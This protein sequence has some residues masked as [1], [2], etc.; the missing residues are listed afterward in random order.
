MLSKDI[1]EKIDSGEISSRRQVYSVVGRT[2]ALRQWMDSEGILLPKRWTEETVIS[3]MRDLKEQLGRLPRAADDWALAGR[4]QDKFGSWNEAMF[5]AFGEY[6]QRRYS[7]YSDE[8]LLNVIRDYVVKF[9]QLPLREEFDGRNYPYFE[10]YTSRF[11]VSTWPDVI[12][13]VDLSSVTYYPR[14]H[15]FGQVYVEDGI[16]YLSRQELLIGRYLNSQKIEFE[17]EVPYGGQTNHTFDFYLPEYNTYIEYYGIRNEDYLG[18]IEAKRNL[19]NGRQVIE[20][21]KHDN[22]VKKL[23]LEVQRL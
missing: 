21:F 14:Q 8:D 16:A 13:L 4:A 12:A 22:T 1:L 2:K 17:R 15:G 6:N 20:I 10:V 7:E 11:G 18:R 5:R 23:A 19:Y 9:Q 3:R